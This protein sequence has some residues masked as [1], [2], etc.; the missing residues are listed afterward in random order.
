MGY[1]EG[2]FLHLVLSGRVFIRGD[3]RLFQYRRVGVIGYDSI[4]GVWFFL[5]GLNAGDGA[6]VASVNSIQSYSRLAGLKLY[7]VAGQTSCSVLDLFS[8]RVLSPRW[9][10]GNLLLLHQSS[11]ALSP[12]LRA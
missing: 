1:G 10:V 4:V 11:H 9:P 6:I 2:G 8:Y 7:L 5:G 12:L 3:F